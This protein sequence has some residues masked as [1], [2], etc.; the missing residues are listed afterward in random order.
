M[1]SIKSLFIAVLALVG[2]AF[3]IGCSM[4]NP[5]GPTDDPTVTL[6]DHGQIL[7]LAP[8]P[9]ETKIFHYDL[10]THKQPSEYTVNLACTSGQP[11]GNGYLLEAR[12]DTQSGKSTI[13]PYLFTPPDQLTPFLKPEESLQ[14]TFVKVDNGLTFERSSRYMGAFAG[15]VWGDTQLELLHHDGSISVLAKG[16][17]QGENFGASA[18][19]NLLPF[20][21]GDGTNTQ[22]SVVDTKSGIVR[23]VCTLGKAALPNIAPDGKEVTC[24]TDSMTSNQAITTV[25]I[26]DGKV[27]S[28]IPVKGRVIQLGYD[29]DGQLLYSTFTPGDRSL[30]VWQVNGVDSVQV[31][32][33]AL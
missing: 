2:S 5:S 6:C 14:D 4:A 26:T 20:I 7:V 8:S 19:G 27:A 24:L 28:K 31:A 22:L 12:G 3:Y 23:S 25:R 21:V 11:Y 32:K 33:V 16:L 30:T 10:K 13:Q 29:S 18:R 1:K 15:K 9:S 17:V